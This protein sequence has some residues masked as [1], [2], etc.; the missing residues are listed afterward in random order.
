MKHLYAINILKHPYLKTEDEVRNLIKILNAGNNF[1]VN[2]GESYIIRRTL[3]NSWVWDKMTRTSVDIVGRLY[4]NPWTEQFNLDNYDENLFEVGRNP[5]KGFLM[6]DN[7]LW[8]LCRFD[9]SMKG[10]N[11]KRL[12]VPYD[13]IESI[14]Q[15]IGFEKPKKL[16]SNNLI[17]YVDNLTPEENLLNIS[18][19]FQQLVVNFDESFKIPIYISNMIN[20]SILDTADDE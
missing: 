19:Q 14:C 2:P 8:G 13:I 11:L 20:N 18:K 6:I 7:T 10:R 16:E 15:K 12:N 17:Y 1:I 4:G 5:N 3:S 9:N